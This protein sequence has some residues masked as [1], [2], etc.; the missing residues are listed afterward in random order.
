MEASFI[1]GEKIPSMKFVITVIFIGLLPLLAFGQNNGSTRSTLYFTMGNTGANVREFNEMLENKGLTPMRKG[2]NNFNLGYQA[3]YNDFII[4]L[5]VSQNPG[6]GSRFNGYDIDYRSTRFNLNV[7]FSFTEEGRFQLIHYMAVGAGFLNFQM[8]QENDFSD[9]S[10]FLNSPQQ[11]FILR[12]G[13]L[14]EGTWKLGGFLTEFG[15]HL[16]YDL[17]IPGFDESLALISRFGYSFSPFEGSWNMKGLTFN[18][19]QSGAFFRLGLGLTLPDHSYFYRDASLGAHLFYGMHFSAPE[20]LNTQLEEN[21]L[22]PFSGRPN[23][24]GLKI[25][26]YNRQFLYGLDLFNLGL[27]G[28]ASESQN[29]T[30]NSVRL[31][32]NGGLKF[33]DLRNI[34]MGALAGLGYGNLRY[35][36][37]SINKPNFPRLFEEPD[38]DG[39]LR[40]YGAMVKPE[41]FVTYGIP[42]SKLNF[43]DLILGMHVGYELP[44]APFNLGGLSMY[45]YMSNPYLQLSVGLRP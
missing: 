5:D 1:F 28:K 21:G 24:W 4:G 16:S 20:A 22:Q 37:T 30:L 25:L 42:L 32:A 45:S 18:N 13:N 26:G 43:F 27:G 35:T 17:P 19:L 12:D 7:G 14:H 33:L 31:Y 40:S 11:G 41:V 10:E 8:L 15:F 38:F 36:L 9:I 23:N 6:P 3:R 39:Q 29:H 34:E 44:I 2:Y